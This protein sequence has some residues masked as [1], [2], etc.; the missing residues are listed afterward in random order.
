MAKENIIEVQNLKTYFHTPEGIVKSVDGVSFSIEKGKTMALVGESG[1]GKTQ[2]SLSLIRLLAP[3]AKV[4]ADKIEI[5]GKETKD[6]TKD[7]ARGIRGKD[8]SMIFQEPMTSLNP[9]YRVKRQLE[10][11]IRLHQPELSKQDT[12]QRALNI[13]TRVGIPEPQERIRVFPH[14]LSGGLRQRVMIA[15]ALASNPRLLIADEPTTA[16]DVTIQAQIIELLK[17]IQKEMEM[18]ILLITHDFGVVSQMADTVS[19]MY[20][21]K[22]VEQGSMKDIFEDP[23]H[24]Y[25]RL[26]IMSIPGIK[27]KRG[28]R[29][30]TIEGA[31]PNPMNFPPGCRFY[32]RCPY[33][34][35]RCMREEPVPEVIGGRMVRCLKRGVHD[36]R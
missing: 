34:E 13:L 15:I 2:T 10:E 21:G 5:N 30:E 6:Y 19:V 7:Q 35:E 18:S 20:A 33:A 32:P 17:E 27:V 16:L 23:W 36:G 14:Q 28:G 22:I 9:V 1:C 25:T 8:I 24:P 12:Y 29:L 26:L 11:M 4:S 31:V 3:T